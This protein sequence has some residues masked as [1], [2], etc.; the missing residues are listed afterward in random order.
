MQNSECRIQNSGF[1]VAE[2]R[3]G[4]HR[5]FNACGIHPEPRTASP[6]TPVRF[7][8]SEFCIL[9]CASPYPARAI[10]IASRSRWVT[11]A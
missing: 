4:C 11:V 1:R 6:L 5:A 2:F 10:S 9:H 3:S 8:N 7:L